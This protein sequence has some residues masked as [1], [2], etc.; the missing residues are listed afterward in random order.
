MPTSPPPF[1]TVS[2]GPYGFRITQGYAGETD[3]Y[4]IGVPEREALD[5]LRTERVR[6]KGWK[7]LE[8][9]RTKSGRRTLSEGE[10]K[11]LT[12]EVA[13]FDREIRL[14]RTEGTSKGGSGVAVGRILEHPAGPGSATLDD[15]GEFD[16]E[17]TRL[18]EAKVDAEE[19][20]RGVSLAPT[21]REAAIAALREEPL[22]REAA[23]AR[24]EASAGERDRILADLF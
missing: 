19:R 6:K 24:V 12:E 16:T 21:Q 9:L 7:V 3:G 20:A 10:L 11:F 5:V 15:H 17:L 8:K 22:L 18:A 23:R 4:E 13:R 1:R 2:I 14:E